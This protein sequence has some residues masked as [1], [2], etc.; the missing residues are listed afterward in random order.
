[1]KYDHDKSQRMSEFVIFRLN[2]AQHMALVQ[3]A[4]RQQMSI[5]DVMRDALDNYCRIGML[6]GWSS[7][8]TAPLSS[9]SRGASES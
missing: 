4:A 9:G 6:A 1:M 8:S 3:A 5:S 2:A 7:T